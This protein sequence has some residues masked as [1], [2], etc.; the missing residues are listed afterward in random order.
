MTND[1]IRKVIMKEKKEDEKVRLTIRIPKQ[2]ND[3]LEKMC[4]K[5]GIT[6][7]ALITKILWESFGKE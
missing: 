7:N 1:V 4:K 3:E 6:K 2:I 5:I